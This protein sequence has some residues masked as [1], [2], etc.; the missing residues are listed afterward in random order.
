MVW[1]IIWKLQICHYLLKN[2]NLHNNHRTLL[3]HLINHNL[4]PIISFLKCNSKFQMGLMYLNIFKHN[5]KM[6]IKISYFNSLK[7]M[8]NINLLLLFLGI[9]I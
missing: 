7:L 3:I 6:N 2:I 4:E 5:N 9:F 1:T 8:V